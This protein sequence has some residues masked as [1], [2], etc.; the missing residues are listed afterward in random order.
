MSWMLVLILLLGLV[1][2]CVI[3]NLNSTSEDEECV[4]DKE[5]RGEFI[6]DYINSN[7]CVWVRINSL[8]MSFK[9]GNV[10]FDK[11]DYKNDYCQTFLSYVVIDRKVYDN[12]TL[13][14][15]RDINLLR[16]SDES[17]GHYEITSFC[18]RISNKDLMDYILNNL[19]KVEEV[20][21]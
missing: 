12:G 5:L 21:Q 1:T 16:A 9:I 20:K 2:V 18:L 14:I 8:P 6:K 10:Y 13:N 19:D 7:C 4:S 3:I 11:Y 17:N 15:L